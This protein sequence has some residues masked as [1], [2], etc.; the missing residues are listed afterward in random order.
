MGMSEV[1]FWYV[2]PVFWIPPILK[3]L[4]PPFLVLVPCVLDLTV[5][6]L[7]RHNNYHLLEGF[8]F[9]YNEGVMARALDKRYGVLKPI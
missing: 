1:Y 5:R 8:Y 9:A 3:W 2:R 4:Q 7:D 6:Q